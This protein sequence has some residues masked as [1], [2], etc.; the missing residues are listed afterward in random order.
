[1][2]R[3]LVVL[4]GIVVGVLGLASVHQASAQDRQDKVAEARIQRLEARITTLEADNTKLRSVLKLEDPPTGVGRPKLRIDVESF[5]L[6]TG[7]GIELKSGDTLKLN[8]SSSFEAR[9]GSTAKLE[10]QGATTIRG[11]TVNIN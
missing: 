6:W 1:M 9:A 3:K 10:C 7:Q 5:V 8:A 2:N 4:S 11:A